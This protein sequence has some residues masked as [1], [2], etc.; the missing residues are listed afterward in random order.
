ME[1][2]TKKIGK[3]LV[4]VHPP[5]SDDPVEAKVMEDLRAEASSYGLEQ[6]KLL[7]T[8]EINVAEARHRI[9]VKAA[10]D[11]SMN[12]LTPDQF[13]ELMKIGFRSAGVLREQ[14]AKAS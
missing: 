5:C 13:E 4:V 9:W 14:L 10:M 2:N 1:A 7:R 3:L 12:N 8:D 11:D 6:L